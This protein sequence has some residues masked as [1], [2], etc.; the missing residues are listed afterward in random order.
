M[1]SAI[2][3]LTMFGGLL[4]FETEEEDEPERSGGTDEASSR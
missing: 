2:C 3:M 1:R 4:D